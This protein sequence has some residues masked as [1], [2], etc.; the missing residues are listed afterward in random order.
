MPIPSVWV[1]AVFGVSS[2][3]TARFIQKYIP[4]VEYILLKFE[5]VVNH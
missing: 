4:Y 2:T 5:A 1:R 3:C